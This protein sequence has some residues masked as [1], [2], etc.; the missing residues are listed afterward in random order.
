MVPHEQAVVDVGGLEGL[1]ACLE[2]FDPAVKESA[3]WTLGVIAKQND[4]KSRKQH[5]F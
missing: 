1:Q 4:G 5:S 3:L 2:T